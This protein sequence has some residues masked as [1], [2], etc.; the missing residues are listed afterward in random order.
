MKH[1]A[2]TV[3]TIRLL[4]IDDQRMVRDG[5][6]AML[7]SQKQAYHFIIEEADSGETG[8][9][10]VIRKDFDIILIDYS[11]PGISGAE[12]TQQIL[13]YRGSSKIL[14]LSNYDEYAYI[15]RMI[16]AGAKGYIL[17]NIEPGQLIQA[18]RTT[19]EGKAYYS[20]EIAIKLIEHGVK[21]GAWSKKAKSILSDRELEIL[22]LLAKG[23][24]NSEIASHLF[25]SKRTVDTHRQ[26]MLIKLKADNAI[27]LILAALKLGLLKGL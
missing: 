16:Q 15:D 3:Q 13:L 7:L 22:N 26:N 11:L 5:I 14:A 1:P 24:T 25:L 2:Y 10:K 23:L 18:I 8:V 21:S 27:S 6:R 4:I 19:M 12:A 9:P 20:P 17:K